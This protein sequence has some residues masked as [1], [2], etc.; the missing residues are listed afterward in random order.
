MLA[1]FLQDMNETLGRSASVVATQQGTGTARSAAALVN[2]AS[3]GLLSTA[4]ASVSSVGTTATVR[5]AADPLSVLA[6]IQQGIGSTSA[7]TT[8]GNA[9]TA[10]AVLKAAKEAEA[11]AGN[12][13]A[14][15]T[16]AVG[17][18]TLQRAQNK[19]EQSALS[20]A[21]DKTAVPYRAEVS[22]I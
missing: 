16:V 8:A 4:Q 14:T 9:E 5:Y 21:V 6:K 1:A 10:E 11:L 2:G 22:S 7:A 12:G 3:A 17:N 20:N 13:K 18:A 19:A 15:V